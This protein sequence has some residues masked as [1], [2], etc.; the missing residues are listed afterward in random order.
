[1]VRAHKQ[2]RKDIHG[3]YELHSEKRETAIC[4]QGHRLHNDGKKA[5]SAP[6]QESDGQK[7]AGLRDVIEAA[8]AEGGGLGENVRAGIVLTA[9]SRSTN[10]VSTEVPSTKLG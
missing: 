5:R 1:M 4:G 2:P 9:R 7:R 8:R 10:Q 6:C 3:F